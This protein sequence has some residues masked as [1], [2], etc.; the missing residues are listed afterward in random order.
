MYGVCECITDVTPGTS[1]LNGS[2][3]Q[4]AYLI[5]IKIA[6]ARV[7]GRRRVYIYL[8]ILV[9]VIIV[10]QSLLAQIIC[11][12]AF[13]TKIV[14]I[15]WHVLDAYLSPSHFRLRFNV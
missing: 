10:M 6:R 11:C 8:C 1:I 14:L 15:G 13:N 4:A 2:S 12:A 3:I 9:P 7:R 5:A